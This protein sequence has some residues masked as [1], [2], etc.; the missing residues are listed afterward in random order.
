MSAREVD[1]SVSFV[2]GGVWRGMMKTYG[3]EIEE[4]DYGAERT[5]KETREPVGVSVR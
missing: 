2:S 1:E 3:R 4:E 5:E